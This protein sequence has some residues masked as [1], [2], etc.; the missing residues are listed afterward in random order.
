ML[1]SLVRRHQHSSTRVTIVLHHTV[2]HV[3]TRHHTSSHV[4]TRLHTSTFVT[5]QS[6]L[7]VIT[8]V[9]HR[10]VHPR[11]RLLIILVDWHAVKSRNPAHF[12]GATHHPRSQPERSFACN[13]RR[14]RSGRS[15]NSLSG[16]RLQSIS[17]CRCSLLFETSSAMH[18]GKPCI[19]ARDNIFI[20]AC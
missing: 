20:I 13:H 3:I 16:F 9:R 8:H 11:S 7:L 5:N 17:A 18:S 14:L 1:S 12:P 6:S 19:I 4:I 10:R 2:S 15:F